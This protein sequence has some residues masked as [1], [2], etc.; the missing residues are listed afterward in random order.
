MKANNK[1]KHR[2]GRPIKGNLT[3]FRNTK[4][5]IVYNQINNL[6]LTEDI[7]IL[8][9]NLLKDALSLRMQYA[10]KKCGKYQ[11]ISDDCRNIIKNFL[12]QFKSHPYAYKFVDCFF[13][14]YNDGIVHAVTINEPRC[15][16]SDPIKAIQHGVKDCLKAVDTYI[17][18]ILPIIENDKRFNNSKLLGKLS[19]VKSATIFVGYY[20]KKINIGRLPLKIGV[21]TFENA[22]QLD[23]NI[24]EYY[25]YN[26][27]IDKYCLVDK[28]NS[29]YSAVNN[30]CA[31]YIICHRHH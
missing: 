7:L 11:L 18:P 4:L 22:K 3:P 13:D 16:T 20:L 29:Y 1:K 5:E 10:L 31:T 28:K 23:A 24:A 19:D 14:S 27:E 2:N 26:H 6:Y 21:D 9:R 17:K 15:R 30:L 12:K 25:T 8:L